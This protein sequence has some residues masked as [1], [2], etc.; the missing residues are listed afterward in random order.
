[1]TYEKGV[2]AH[3]RMAF[4]LEVEQLEPD[5]YKIHLGMVR[6][7]TTRT[8]RSRILPS[9]SVR[10]ELVSTSTN[11]RYKETGLQSLT[12]YWFAVCAL[13]AAGPSALSDPVIGVAA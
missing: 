9:A 12:R 6:A 11:T 4:E 2:P 5:L 3:F 13:G 8:A 1:M 7:C 10:R